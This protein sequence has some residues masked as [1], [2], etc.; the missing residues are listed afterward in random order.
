MLENI[1]SKIKSLMEEYRQSD[2]CKNSQCARQKWQKKVRL[3][4]K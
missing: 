1:I 4:R 2:F 3:K